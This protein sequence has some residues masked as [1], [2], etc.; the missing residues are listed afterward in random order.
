[1]TRPISELVLDRV[2]EGLSGQRYVD[3]PVAFAREKFDFHAWS[4]QIA[5]MRSVAAHP[6]TA[7]RAGHGVGKTATAAQVALWF[8][9]TRPRSRVITTA[10][11][12]AQVEQL[13]WREI[14]ASVAR[15]HERGQGG[16]FPK[17][18]RTSLELAEDWFALGLSTNEP[19]RFQGHHAEHLLL[20][21]DEA[22]G[23][24]D[25][26][27]AAAE[28]FLTAEG[29][30]VL[31]IGN[32]TRIGGQFHRAFTQ[33]KTRW[34][35]I[36]IS[37]FDSPNLTGEQVPQQVAR[38]LVTRAWVEDAEEVLGVASPTFQIRVLGEFHEA[39]EDALIPHNRI[40][41]AQ[42]R[43]LPDEPIPAVVACDIARSSDR[44]VIYRN[45]G[46]RVRLVRELPHQDLMRT[47]GDLVSILDADPYRA[48]LVLDVVGI[49][50]GVSDRLA[51]QAISH[52]EFNGGEKAYRPDL[53]L[54]RRAEIHYA[55]K[56][57]FERGLVD[58][59]P[60]DRELEAQLGSLRWHHTS[61]GKLAIEGKDVMRRR[62]LPSPDRADSLAMTFALGDAWRPK[63]VPTPYDEARELAEEVEA[64]IAYANSPEAR[65]ANAC[66]PEL[67]DEEL[68]NAPM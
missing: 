29:A 2:T 51:E 25:G 15:A 56:D 31:L 43:E 1:M 48:P 27:Y 9:A 45:A 67:T 23:V 18:N 42:A 44:T 68:L 53:Y 3:D 66:G 63:R 46:G 21:V 65:I 20:I 50:R 58:L 47:T 36:H 59:D 26:I 39:S 35:T 10:P 4:K 57:A 34:N 8:L 12:F 41:E 28:G 49:G 16:Q 38:A 22:S 17:P 60:N 32:P 24:D 55:M 6:R 14:R 19:E 61:S 13:L 64:A 11:T 30:K 52:L 33:E 40:S 7:V 62:G 5:I 54:N 37:A